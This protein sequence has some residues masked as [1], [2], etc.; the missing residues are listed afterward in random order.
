M[1]GLAVTNY[2][3]IQNFTAIPDSLQNKSITLTNVQ[4]SYP[5][6]KIRGTVNDKIRISTAI[7][8]YS[9]KEEKQQQS[10]RNALNATIH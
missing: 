5:Q 8:N 6:N 3:Y 2:N 9:C 10:I 7:S 4:E 1:I